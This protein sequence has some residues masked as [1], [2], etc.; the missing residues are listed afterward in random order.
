MFPF[1]TELG[2]E[3]RFVY[4]GGRG[5]RT[6]ATQEKFFYEE[7]IAAT[8]CGTDIVL[9]TYIVQYHSHRHLFPQFEFFRSYTVELTVQKFSEHN[10]KKP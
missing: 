5:H 2:T 10:W 7:C 6:D 3:S 9:T 4:L 8:K 1:H